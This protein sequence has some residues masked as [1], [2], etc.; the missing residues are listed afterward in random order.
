MAT[1]VSG[2]DSPD[3]RVVDPSGHIVVIIDRPG[4]HLDLRP[5]M[6]L[7]GIKA[8]ICCEGGINYDRHQPR[9]PNN[10]QVADVGS[11]HPDSAVA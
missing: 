4:D 11:D 9:F 10:P 7:A 2:T 1:M 8:P 5:C 3:Q 6:A